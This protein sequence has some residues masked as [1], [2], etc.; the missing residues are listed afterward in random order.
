M[1]EWRIQA[2][3]HICQACGNSF[4]NK[5]VYH[6]LLFEQKNEL[7]RQDLCDNCWQSQYNKTSDKKHE[8][9]SY[10]QG[11]YEVPPPPPPEPIKRETAETLLQKLIEQNNPNFI[12][13]RL[14]LL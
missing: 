10:W 4:E 12:R 3:S 14:S 6:T 1:N 13:Q 5:Q 7:I 2:R 8:F 9:V 11:I